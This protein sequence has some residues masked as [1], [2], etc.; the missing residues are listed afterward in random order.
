[1]P[2]QGFET[3]GNNIY[4]N[5]CSVEPSLYR[6]N[7]NPAQS[8]DLWICRGSG[9]RRPYRSPR[10]IVLICVRPNTTAVSI[11]WSERTSLKNVKSTRRIQSANI[12]LF[13]RELTNK[14]TY[15][16]EKKTNSMLLN[17]SLHL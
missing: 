6:A 10:M 7:G 4:I 3:F 8:S 14:C 15:S 5:I 13:L 17:A 11:S 2:N 1:M 16:V 9:S 12:F